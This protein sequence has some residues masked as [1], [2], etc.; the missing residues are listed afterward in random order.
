MDVF[1]IEKISPTPSL[2]KRG[3]REGGLFQTEYYSSL[4]KREV[5]WDFINL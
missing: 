3:T 4:W 5:R 2:P 1:V